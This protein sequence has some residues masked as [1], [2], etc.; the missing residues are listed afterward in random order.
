MTR[1]YSEIME[2][3]DIRIEPRVPTSEE[4]RRLA[5]RVGWAHAFHWPSVPASLDGS[6]FG[7]VAMAGDEPVGMGRLVG[8]GAHFFYV[9]DVA[10]DPDWQGRGIGQRMVDALLA[11]I[12]EVCTGPVFVGLFASGEAIR[13]YERNGFT[14]GD[15]TGMFRLV[16]PDDE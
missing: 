5:E 16:Q 10:V 8:D 13:L 14:T 6:L 4:H 9:Q 12:R 15:M 11:H 1:E 2:T 7:V 3:S